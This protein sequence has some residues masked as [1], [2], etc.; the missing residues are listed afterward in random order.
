MKEHTPKLRMDVEPYFYAELQ[1]LVNKELIVETTS[2]NVQGVLKSVFP[3]YVTLKT[4]ETSFCI[5]IKKIVWIT[6]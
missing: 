6:K 1:T 5:R 2:G 4:N 3:D